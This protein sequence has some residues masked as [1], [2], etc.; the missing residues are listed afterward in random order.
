[1]QSG[2]GV[3]ADGAAFVRYVPLIRRVLA[4]R[5]GSDADVPDLLQDVLF[6]A[7]RRAPALRNPEGL[8][9]W[10]GTTAWLLAHGRIRQLRRQRQTLQLLGER[11]SL[12]ADSGDFEARETLRSVQRILARM[13][14]HERS[15]F[16]LRFIE[17][18]SLLQIGEACAVSLG[19]VKRRLT[20]AQQ[21]FGKAAQREPALRR[22]LER[23]RASGSVS[24]RLASSDQ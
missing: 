8:A 17:G 1:M 5:L 24:L 12:A 16:E 21:A 19:T 18:L 4:R 11:P 2:I 13:R 14:P 23:G 10:L 9:S 7:W 22:R 6:L 3:P 20:R 15:V